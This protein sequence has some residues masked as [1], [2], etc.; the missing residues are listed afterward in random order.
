MTYQ[1]FC[2][3]DSTTESDGSA[4]KGPYVLA[5]RKVFSKPQAEAFA[6]TI[7]AS[8]EPIVKNISQSTVM[9]M[10]DMLNV[11]TPAH[12]VL[13]QSWSDDEE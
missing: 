8:R 3:E 9:Q 13:L 10:L 4:R 5:T 1:V 11:K 12:S 7:N 2:R 6:K